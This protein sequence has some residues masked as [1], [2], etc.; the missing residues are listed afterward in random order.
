MKIFFISIIAILSA[1][2]LTAQIKEPT[3]KGSGCSCGFTSIIQGGLLE[4]ASGPSWNLQSI[5]GIK[6]KTWSAGIGVA[7]DYY[8]MRTIPLF[9]DIRKELFKKNRT[10]FLYADG[11]IQF[12]WLK[13]KEKPGWGSS[14]YNR[15]YYYD[16]GGGYKFG[17]GK[18]DAFLVSAGYTMKTLREERI[19]ILQCIQA[20]CNPTKDYYKFSFSRLTFK[21]GWQFR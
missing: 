17:I 11:G 3:A 19:T 21:V 7:L 2:P 10:P 13:T 15:G 14:E 20:P 12:D 8:I 9:I 5:N 4:G 18:R 6:Y 1:V 16:I